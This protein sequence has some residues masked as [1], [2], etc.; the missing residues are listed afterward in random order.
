MPE[1]NNINN[2]L[3]LPL[4]MTHCRWC[5]APIK[6]GD[7]FCKHC[8]EYQ[9]NEDLIKYSKKYLKDS[10]LSSC[11]WIIVLFFQIIAI[12][13]GIKHIFFNEK[14]RGIKVILLSFGLLAFKALF[15]FL[16]YSIN[17]A[18]KMMFLI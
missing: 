13:L 10:T 12:F 3:S 7:N 1:D 4:D 11:D 9:N 15:I 17:K 16:F 14:I 2:S 18:I 5:K 6:N 8:N